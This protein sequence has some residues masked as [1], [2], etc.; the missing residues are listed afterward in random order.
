M[1]WKEKFAYDL[2]CKA[3]DK[4]KALSA[5][6]NFAAEME[7]V[8]N[9]YCV[10]NS[11]IEI[12]ESKNTIRICN[13]IINW[14]ITGEKFELNSN[15]GRS[16]NIFIYKNKYKVRYCENNSAKK[17]GIYILNNSNSY[18]DYVDKAFEYLLI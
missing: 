2:C 16:V 18:N 15:N 4:E 10:K 3:I 17:S 7:N 1:D 13:N 5:I 11:D 9:M 6:N 8:L 12:D 14:D